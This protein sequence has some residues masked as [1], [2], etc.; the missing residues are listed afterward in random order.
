LTCTYNELVVIKNLPAKKSLGPDV[1]NYEF[2]Q[3]FKEQQTPM[4][5]KQ[6]QGSDDT[7]LILQKSELT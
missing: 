5:L 3:T 2:Y 6:F 4:L 7:R 1:S